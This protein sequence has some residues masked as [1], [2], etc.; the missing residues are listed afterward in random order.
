MQPPPYQ[1]LPLLSH[2]NH[3]PHYLL[4]PYV[5]RLPNPN[6]VLL[7]QILFLFFPTSHPVVTLEALWSSQKRG[8]LQE[9]L[10]PQAA[11]HHS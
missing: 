1:A 9:K 10:L 8:R 6:L 4:N 7:I 2:H 5:I 3:E 11:T